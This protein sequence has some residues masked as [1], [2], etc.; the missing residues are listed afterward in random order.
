MEYH[1]QYMESIKSLDQRVK[2]EKNICAEC[3]KK[4][5][6]KIYLCTDGWRW[7]KRPPH[8]VVV[9]RVY[10]ANIIFC[11]LVNIIFAKYFCFAQRFLLFTLSKFVVCR[12]PDGMHSANYETLGN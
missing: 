6:G 8:V 2:E 5:L 4:T 1:V 3:H 7:S 9:C 11:H 12:V 10:S